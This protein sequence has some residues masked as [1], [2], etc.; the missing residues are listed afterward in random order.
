[1]ALDCL[2]KLSGD[3]PKGTIGV[4]KP[5]TFKRGILTLKVSSPLVSSELKMRS[6]GLIND[7]NKSFGKKLVSGL[8]FRVN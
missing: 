8:K 1:M 7:I 3:L 4:I 5:V 6:D 2:K